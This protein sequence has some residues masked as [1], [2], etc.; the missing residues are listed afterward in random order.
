VTAEIWTIGHWTCPQ[1]TFVG[2]LNAQRIELVAD[3]RSYPESRRSPQFGQET[4]RGWLEHAGIGYLHL[5][6]LGGRRRGQ[7]VDPAV[8]A[9]WIQPSFHNYADYTLRPAYQHGIDRLM[10]L[11]TTH[12]VAYLCGEPMPWRCHRLLISNTLAARG[13]TVW[14]IIGERDPR[15]H[16]LGRWGAQPSIDRDGRLT[17][18][19]PISSPDRQLPKRMQAR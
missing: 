9:G 11:A 5:P 15:R 2:F 19:P 3:V 1:S 14:H 4:M 6:E 8:N 7:D 16:E 10:E 13:W 17:Y 12:R 18:P